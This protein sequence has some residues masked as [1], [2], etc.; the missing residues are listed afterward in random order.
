MF[1]RDVRRLTDYANT[2][3]SA[4]GIGILMQTTD[5]LRDERGAS[6][7]YFSDLVTLLSNNTVTLLVILFK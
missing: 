5:G 4:D 2:T 7:P 1:T 3:G 6:G